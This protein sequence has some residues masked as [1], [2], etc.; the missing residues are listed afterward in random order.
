MP[1]RAPSALAQLGLA[2]GAVAVAI[3]VRQLLSP[4]LGTTFP[5]ATMFTA[6]AFVVWRAG[7]A[8]ALGVAIGGWIAVGF[9]MR[10]GLNYFG[11]LTINE[12]VGFVTYLIAAVPVIVLGEAMRRAQQAFEARQSELASINLAL[13]TKVEAQSLLA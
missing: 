9:I 10:G 2:I 6:V 12:I 8:P 5:L 4:W 13:E 11:G 1:N 3:I 7:W